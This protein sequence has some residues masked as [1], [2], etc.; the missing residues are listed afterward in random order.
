MPILKMKGIEPEQIRNISVSMVDELEKLLQCPR[1]YFVIEHIP[2][3]FIR[4]GSI[5]KGYPIVEVSM[6]DRGMEAQ[7][8]IAGTITRYIKSQVDQTVDVYFTY[9]QRSN[10]YENGEHF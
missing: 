7:D 8:K 6:F 3:V 5:D 10:Y 9:L 1:E 2:V 4:E